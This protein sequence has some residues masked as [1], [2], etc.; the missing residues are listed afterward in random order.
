[1]KKAPL[2][3]RSR[4]E[5]LLQGISNAR[6]ALMG[7]LCL[8]MYWLCDM[9]LS[10]LSRETPH[11]P[12]P[13]VE[14]RFSPG[15]AGNV[16]ANLAALGPGKLSVIGMVGADWRGKLLRQALAERGIDCS[17]VLEDGDVVTNTYIKPLRRGISQVVYED[18]RLDFENRKPLPAHCEE[19][20]LAALEASKNDWDVLCVSDQMAFGCITP[21]IREKICE[22][23]QMGKTII[24]DS[25]NHCAD[26]RHVIIKPNEVESSRAFHDGSPLDR[27][28]LACL[29]PQIS[30]KTERDALITMGGEGCL[31]Y[32]GGEII[33]C[34]ACKVPPPID[35]CG[36]GDTF[37]SGFA[38]L[39]CAG[40]KPYEAAQ[41]A[42]LCSA[43]T[44]R[45]LDTTGTAQRE[46]VLAAWDAYWA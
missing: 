25:R 19:K 18:P 1:M 27:E 21:A 42:N 33:H 17:R 29:I 26:Y 35:F 7:D 15:G 22:M 23:G 43:V 20:L 44:I 34:P 5:E 36:A 13:V 10:E 37:L 16:A 4:L 14:E 9:R 39:L 24:V 40:A 3:S 31:M 45:K 8:D 46:E 6:L 30:E 12:M 32:T 11:F 28:A 2:L 41:I 38:S